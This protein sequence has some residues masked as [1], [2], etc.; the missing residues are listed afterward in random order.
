MKLLSIEDDFINVLTKITWWV[1]VR[2]DKGTVW[3]SL[4]LIVFSSGVV[5]LL[6]AIDSFN[7]MVQS[8]SDVS[9]WILSTILVPTVGTILYS[10]C[11]WSVYVFIFSMLHGNF[12]ILKNTNQTPN[13]NKYNGW[14]W[15]CRVQTISPFVLGI[16]QHN[17]FISVVSVV[18]IVVPSLY[19]LC[20]DQ[21]PPAKKKEM[22][23]EVENK[24]LQLSP[25]KN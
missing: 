23:E 6:F 2:F 17:M 18:I 4:F 13:P 14:V 24:R 20:V 16:V 10:V 7:S 12:S 1:S 19:I 9:V 8:A 3:L 25:Q 5:H 22:Q 21:I 15:M 11:I